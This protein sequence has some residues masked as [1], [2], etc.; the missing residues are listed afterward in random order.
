MGR[1]FI[2]FFADFYRHAIKADFNDHRVTADIVSKNNINHSSPSKI[3]KMKT[4]KLW[5]ERIWLSMASVLFFVPVVSIPVSW[6]VF[7]HEKWYM[8]V[9]VICFWLFCI[10]KLGMFSGLLRWTFKMN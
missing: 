1:F 9:A 8:I 5:A 7:V 4:S 2:N 3:Y 10:Y 6:N